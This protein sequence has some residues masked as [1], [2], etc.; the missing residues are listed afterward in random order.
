MPE[1]HSMANSNIRSW[2]SLPASPSALAAKV[3]KG[4]LVINVLDYLAKG[5]NATDDTAAI[6]AAI[7]AAGPGG[8]VYFPP[9]KRFYCATA[10]NLNNG[11]ILRGGGY[12][13]NRDFVATIGMAAGYLDTS[14]IVG[15][16]IRSGVTS[17]DGIAH[18]KSTIHA[19]G[20][21]RDLALIGPGSGT[22]NGINF[23]N[24]TPRAVLAPVYRNVLVCNFATGL[25][26][27]HVNEGEFT[28]ILV[29]GCTTAISCVD[30]VNDVGWFKLNMQRC[31]NGL[32]Q[33]SGGTC[34]SNSF[35]SPICQNITNF[36][37]QLRGFSH[38]L[39]SPY[40]EL[41]G[42]GTTGNNS[43]MSFPGA[44]NCT[45]TS[46]QKQGAGTFTIDIASGS[47]FNHFINVIL[48]STMLIANSGTGS[49]FTGNL[50]NGARITGANNRVAVDLNSATYEVPSL[51][52]TSG[53]RPSLQGTNFE[54]R[55]GT[56]G[57]ERRW[58][59]ATPEAA[60][61][62][63]IGSDYRRTDNGLSYSKIT[64]AG[65]TGWV[66]NALCISNT[67]TLDFASIAAG[68]TAEL[69]ITVT[70]AATGDAVSVGPP[71][72]LNAG[73]Q[74]TGYVSATNTVTV[75]VYNS[76]GSAVDPASSTW[77]ATVIR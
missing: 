29:K 2:P 77:K 13:I 68:A 70:G 28:S 38:T 18:V 52:T 32:I 16:V 8:T 67:A 76:T 48:S 3:T 53:S 5:D 50:D 36:G 21:I 44:S 24:A 17:G 39:S 31:T 4:E 43:M 14:M 60:Q 1:G 72:T 19:G 62:S 10:L 51:S 40:F 30:D 57:S 73:L 6:Q 47:N 25:K 27:L 35:V 46:P 41:C 56:G 37:F 20:G 12:Y 11:Q 65:N 7:D 63:P 22:S 58:G 42:A 15:S 26:M 75:R 45:V 34:Y 59:S 64:G 69:T 61:T 33:E 9:G 54:Y 23:G 55:N 49:F 66:Q 74:V 71:S